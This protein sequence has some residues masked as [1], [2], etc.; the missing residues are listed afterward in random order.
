MTESKGSILGGYPFAAAKEDPLVVDSV[1]EQSVASVATDQVFQSTGGNP[2]ST[3]SESILSEA[4]HTC[5]SDSVSRRTDCGRRKI[6]LD[7]GTK[8]ISQA[9]PSRCKRKYNQ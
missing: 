3:A 2:L 7:S 4:E 6:H 5:S 9:D 8:S 1:S